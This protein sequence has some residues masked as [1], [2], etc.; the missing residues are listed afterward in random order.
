MAE[1]R[2]VATKAAIRKEATS[3]NNVISIA[4]WTDTT[5]TARAS[6]IEC[7]KEVVDIARTASDAMISGLVECGG[8]LREL[9][10]IWATIIVSSLEETGRLLAGETASPVKVQDGVSQMMTQFQRMLEVNQRLAERQVEAASAVGQAL[11]AMP[12]R[13]LGSRGGA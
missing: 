12:S 8:E 7:S 6:V 11:S 9:N 2:P 10:S 4:P 5:A 3:P 1:A 13:I